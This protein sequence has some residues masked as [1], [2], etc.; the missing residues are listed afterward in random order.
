MAKLIPT[1]NSCKPRMT[2]GENRLAERL[3]KKLEDDYLLWYDVPIGPKQLKPDFVVLHPGRGFLVLEVKDWK[4]DTIQEADRASVTLLTDRGLVRGK[5]PLLQAKVYALEVATALQRDRALIYPQGHRYFGKLLMPYGWGAV[6]T[7]ITRSQFDSTNLGE[8]INPDLTVCKD[9]MLESVD[10][11]EFQQ[12][13]WRMFNV[14]FPCALSLPQVDRV[15]WHLFPEIRVAPESNQM[16]MFDGAD[17]RDAIPD[18]VKVMDMQQEQ[19]ARSMG[20]GHRVIHGV[21]GSGKTMILG[22]RSL[23]LA[24]ALS[25]PVLVLCYNVTLAA[26]LR[27]LIESRDDSHRVVVRSFHAWCREMLVT[28][29]VDLPARGDGFFENMVAKVID[30]V[31]RGQVP[32]AQYG[33]VLLDEGHDFQRD[34]FKLIVQ[35]VDPTTGSLLVLYDDAQAIYEKKSSAKFSFASVGIQAQGRTTILKLNY[36]NTL[37]VL[38]VAKTFA[39]E[40][41]LTQS[42]DDDGVPVIAPESAGRRGPVPELIRCDSAWDE[43]KLIAARVSDEL[44]HGRALSDIAIVYRSDNAAANIGRAL[45][46]NGIAYRV[47]KGTEGKRALFDGDPAVKLVSMHSSK[48]LEFGA[49]FVPELGLM[50]RAMD[51]E[52]QEARLLYVAMTRA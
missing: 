20:D 36:R 34:W 25:K 16:G 1:F 15:R 45:E 33:A 50:P 31:E 28:Y 9:E 5:N 13:L 52:T 21:A 48:G 47:A 49:V 22:Y 30:G 29:H 7:N 26:R 11:H 27:G 38:S 23:Y 3:E 41:L 8:V 17:A 19:L 51:A 14:V 10:P 37:E 44:G 2:S 42:A 43:A 46:Q 12:R 39:K 35:M 40:L 24:Q 32:R 18:V 6:L 4:L